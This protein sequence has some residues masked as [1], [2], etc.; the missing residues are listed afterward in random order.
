MI[1]KNEEK[2]IR[3]ALSWAKGIA[4]EQ[5]VVDT[6]S[7]DRTVEIAEE[8]GAKVYHFKWIDDFSAAKNFAIEQATGDWIAFLDADEYFKNEDIH[9]L[10]EY[11]QKIE[12]FNQQS[13]KKNQVLILRLPLFNL[14]DDGQVFS[15]T[16]QDRIFRNIPQ[17][18]YENKIHEQLISP[19]EDFPYVHF[20]G[21]EKLPIYHT[22]Y[23]QKV[24]ESSN[25][26]QRNIILLEKAIAENPKS[27]KILYH[28]G[29][30]YFANH[31]IEKAEEVWK[32]ALEVTDP[33]EDIDNKMNVIASLLRIYIDKPEKEEYIRQLYQQYRTMDHNFAD[34]DYWM[35][36]YCMIHQYYEEAIE[37][38]QNVIGYLETAEDT[39]IYY[40]MGHL[41][42]IYQMLI[43]ANYE[44]G[45]IPEVVQYAVQCLQGDKKQESVLVVLLQLFQR[46]NEKI[47]G[48]YGF[49]SKLY[50]F[51]DLRDILFVAK[52]AKLADY[53]QFSDYML[54]KIPEEDK[55]KYGIKG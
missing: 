27:T 1:V 9:Y 30:S 32:Q 53:N 5:I 41:V 24:Y 7:T 4:F 51:D 48:V 43:Q 46:A 39:N 45:N 20:L 40:C 11:I 50:H 29:N 2:N 49:L 10:F 19:S 13:S 22:G 25:K 33:Q 54:D 26:A 31:Q 36:C 3:Q 52:C 12:R 35:G 38:L 28:L 17:L 23:A 42:Q 6:G 18:R 21:D 55:L 44:L 16:V 37:H 34:I 8:M 15:S 14:N 47:E